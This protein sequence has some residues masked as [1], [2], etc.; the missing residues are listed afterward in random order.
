MHDLKF[1][2]K[3]ERRNIYKAGFVIMKGKNSQ[4]IWQTSSLYDKSG[5]V[6]TNNEIYVGV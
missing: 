2:N 5:V 6:L 4:E 1:G 3:K